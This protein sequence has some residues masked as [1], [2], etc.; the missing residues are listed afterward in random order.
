MVKKL[1]NELKE[2]DST[3]STRMQIEVVDQIEDKN[4]FSKT[5]PENFVQIQGD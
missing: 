2:K 5:E 1:Q 3:K 4:P